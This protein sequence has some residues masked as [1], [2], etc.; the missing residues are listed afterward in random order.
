MKKFNNNKNLK[1]YFPLANQDIIKVISDGS[2]YFERAKI[3]TDARM[4]M[5]VAQLAHESANFSRLEEMK[6]RNTTFEE[7]YGYKT[8]VGK[9]LGNTKSG[10]GEK[11]HGRGII[12]L[13]G[14]WNY[15]SYGATI[16]EDLENHPE[17]AAE[18]FI[19]LKIAVAYWHRRGVN[20][21]A[22]KGDV[23]YATKLINGGHNG[24]RDR[25]AIYKRLKDITYHGVASG[26]FR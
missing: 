19:A 18:P 17:L 23:R 11:Y 16:G 24:L 10:D 8:R 3:N 15:V 20:K 6:Y 25:E 26:T 1:Y 14:L 7:K 12:Q 2:H 5:F 21:A 9:I 13:T 4:R 22:D